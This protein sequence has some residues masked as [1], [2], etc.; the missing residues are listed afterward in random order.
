MVSAGIGDDISFDLEM[1]KLGFELIALDPL[2]R[3]AEFAKKSIPTSYNS[4]IISKGLWDHSGHAKFFWPRDKS[5]DSFSITNLQNVPVTEFV[6]YQTLDIFDLFTSEPRLM[7]VNNY[8]YLKMDVEGAEL[9]ILNRMTEKNIEVNM[10]AVEFDVLSLI[11]VAS[12][13]HR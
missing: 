5:H 1:L 7:D 11:P 4:L 13:R 2:P 8:V 10:L 12:F 9:S 3:C 6:S